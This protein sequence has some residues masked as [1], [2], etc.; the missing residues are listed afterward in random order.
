MSPDPIGLLRAAFGTES[1]PKPFHLIEAA[2]TPEVS[3]ENLSP[4]ARKRIGKLRTV[5]DPYLEALGLASSYEPD[6]ARRDRVAIMLGQLMLGVLA[7]REFERIYKATMGTADLELEDAR[8]ARSDTDYRV[9]NGHKRP[10][11]RI[12]IKFHGTLFRQAKELVGLEP[13]D[14]FAL[15]TYKIWQGLNK[16]EREK[17]PYL[18]VVVSCPIA[19]GDV[20]EAIPSEW[21]RLSC[22]VHESKKTTSKRLTEEK[23]AE[24]LISRP[25]DSFAAHVADLQDA[26]SKAT[27][28]VLSAR[29][30]DKLLRELLFARVYAVRVRTFTRSYRNA[31]VDMHFSLSSDMTQLA[32]FLKEIATVGLHGIAVQLE[33][34]VM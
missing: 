16:Q 14:C 19:A 22:L 21:V 31:E 7:E 26:L 29:R 11:F 4:A 15:A 33:R 30:A 2:L 27:W 12:N 10:V 3:I 32:V 18:F 23:I 24:Y 8:E 5:S 17:L 1:L 6:Q 34:G 9:L 13:T 20:A 25:P 28:R